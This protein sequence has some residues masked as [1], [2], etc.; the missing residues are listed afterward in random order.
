MSI[1]MSSGAIIKLLMLNSAEHEICPAYKSQTVNNCK[2]HVFLGKQLLLAFS[3]LLAEKISCSDEHE[4]SFITSGPGYI[5]AHK[6]NVQYKQG[7]KICLYHSN[8]RLSAFL[9]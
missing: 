9:N 5:Q 7:G 8:S 2:L 1:I 4:K 3:Y 6:K